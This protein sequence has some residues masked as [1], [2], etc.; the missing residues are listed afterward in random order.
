MTNEPDIHYPWLF[1][2]IKGEEWRTQK[3]L[4]RLMKTHF[5]NE[6][7]GLPGNDDTG[8]L[9]TWIVYSMMGIYPVLPGDMNYAIA[10][11][12]FDEVKIKLDA[13]FYPGEEFIIRKSGSF[14]ETK[15][16]KK[17]R[18]NGKKQKNFFIHHADLV[19]G[20]VL[21]ILY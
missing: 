2:Y 9:S 12:V 4:N 8:T 19:K 5:K 6:P 18:F 17:I 14:G 13:N 3:E 10:S 15:R 7:G 11:P 20:G 16:I 21:E 1:N